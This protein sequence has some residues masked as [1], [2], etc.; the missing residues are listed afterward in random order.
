MRKLQLA[1]EVV[2]GSLS[3]KHLC[4]IRN[5]SRKS[6]ANASK[7]LGVLV[8]IGNG[9]PGSSMEV[10]PIDHVLGNGVATGEV[11]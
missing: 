1:G 11:L 10:R 6:K 9:W 2:W 4:C 3:V 7:V 5:L 8:H